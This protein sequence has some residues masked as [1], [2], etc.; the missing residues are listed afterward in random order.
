MKNSSS[1][2]YAAVDTVT[3]LQ[4]IR[5]RR[6]QSRRPAVANRSGRR[7]LGFHGW[8]CGRATSCR[9]LKQMLALC[10]S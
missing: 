7:A 4:Q 6:A 2:R 3:R 9:R 5:N 10:R 1:E 8:S